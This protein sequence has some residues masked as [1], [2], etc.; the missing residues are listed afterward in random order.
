MSQ[1]TDT[2]INIPTALYTHRYVLTYRAIRPVTLTPHS[3][4]LASVFR[5]ALH[6]ATTL[7][8]CHQPND[9]GRR[10]GSCNCFYGKLFDPLAPRDHQHAG[11]FKNPPTPYALRVLTSHPQYS[12]G[13][14]FRIQIDIFG[15]ANDA[16]ADFLRLAQQLPSYFP[17]NNPHHF[18]LLDVFEVGE[19]ATD[20]VELFSH[21]MLHPSFLQH[22]YQTKR[23][24]EFQDNLQ[25]LTVNFWTICCLYQ[26]SNPV[27]LPPFTLLLSRIWE[28]A[29]LLNSFYGDGTYPAKAPNWARI[30]PTEPDILP[31]ARISHWRKKR[32][33]RFKQS[34]KSDRETIIGFKGRFQY[35]APY[36][37]NAFLPLLDLGARIHLGKLN[38][39][40]LGQYDVKIGKNDFRK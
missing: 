3:H 33:R 19:K 39:F 1:L 21:G 30:L 32:T 20:R 16:L 9:T 6:R 15:K 28:R 13:E 8:F 34:H 11:K 17:K 4:E 12:V 31:N 40:G 14:L 29:W 10:C 23:P 25:I 5:G 27:L 22:R 35:Q 37:L 38:V 18:E 2:L 24:D 7:R 36:T 26:R